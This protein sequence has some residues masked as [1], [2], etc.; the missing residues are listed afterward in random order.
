MNNFR[1]WKSAC[2][3]LHKILLVVAGAPVVVGQGQVAVECCSRCH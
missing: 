2:T 1:V 3:H